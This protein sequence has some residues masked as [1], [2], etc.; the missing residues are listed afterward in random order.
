[1]LLTSCLCFYFKAVGL[2]IGLMV[3]FTTGLIVDLAIDGA[4]SIALEIAV[5]LLR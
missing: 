2:I 3:D 1:M 5:G 4:V